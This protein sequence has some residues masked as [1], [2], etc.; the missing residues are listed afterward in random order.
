VATIALLYRI[1]P[2]VKAAS[3]VRLLPGA[4]L[5]ALLWAAG[6]SAFGWYVATLANYTATYGSLATVA[7]L[8]TW[9]WL[10]AAI[11][12]MGAQ[13]NHEIIRRTR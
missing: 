13:V 7:V 9:L 2:S 5:A 1:G 3:Y 11:V 10:S 4:A 8:M 6:S 12:L